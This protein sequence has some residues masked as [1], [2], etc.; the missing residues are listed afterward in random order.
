ML[1]VT[2]AR[3]LQYSTLNALILCCANCYSP[4]SKTVYTIEYDMRRPVMSTT[5]VDHIT[6][7]AENRWDTGL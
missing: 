5:I 1:T 6:M 7:Q 3:A 2:N 4:V